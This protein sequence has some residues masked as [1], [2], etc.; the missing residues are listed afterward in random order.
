MPGQNHLMIKVGFQPGEL[1]RLLGKPMNEILCKGSFDCTELLGNEM[2]EVNDQLKYAVFKLLGDCCLSPTSLKFDFKDARFI[3]PD[4]AIVYSEE[5]LHHD[6]DY[7]VPFH[8][9]KKE[10]QS[11][12]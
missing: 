11:M 10:K 7:D 4:I 8:H 12:K 9:Y 2:I 6:K 1:Y 5:I 3:K